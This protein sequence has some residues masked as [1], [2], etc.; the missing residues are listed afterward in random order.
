MLRINLYR[1]SILPGYHNNPPLFPHSGLSN[2]VYILCMSN[3]PKIPETWGI[4]DDQA[5]KV[6]EALSKKSIRPEDAVQKAVE[7]IARD[8]ALIEPDPVDWVGWVMLF[9]DQL[10]SEAT[11]RNKG[12][13][14]KHVI[15]SLVDELQNHGTRKR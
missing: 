13:D 6:R 2:L 14:F 9:V 11:G 3:N 8:I 15:N 10:E 1:L 4:P 12:F 5:D 7:E